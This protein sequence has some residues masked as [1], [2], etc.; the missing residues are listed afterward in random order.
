[1]KSELITCVHNESDSAFN[2]TEFN[3]FIS[4][5]LIHC[6]VVFIPAITINCNPPF[7]KGKTDSRWISFRQR[8]ANKKELEE[9]LGMSI[10]RWE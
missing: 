9:R 1:M 3:S 2:F 5:G 10:E 4:G 8:P 6:Q 7:V